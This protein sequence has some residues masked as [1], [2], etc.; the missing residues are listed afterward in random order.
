MDPFVWYPK[1][2]CTKPS[3]SRRIEILQCADTL[4]VNTV[5]RIYCLKV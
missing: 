1:M 2:Y 5:N 3:A 4:K